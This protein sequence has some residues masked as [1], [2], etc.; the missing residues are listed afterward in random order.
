[1]LH[2]PLLYLGSKIKQHQILWDYLFSNMLNIS[3]LAQFIKSVLNLDLKINPM[4]PANF[5]ASFQV[6]I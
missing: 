2:F 6:L 1:M 3:Q 4:E 5:W